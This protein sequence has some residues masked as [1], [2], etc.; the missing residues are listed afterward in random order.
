MNIIKITS[1]DMPLYAE[2]EELYKNSFPVFEQRTAEQQIRAFLSPLYNLDIYEENGILIGFISYWDFTSYIYIEHFA[3]HN[4]HR[5]K[6]YG[7]RLLN[8]FVEKNHKM[9]ILEI[10]PIIDDISSA[11]LRFYQKCNF[12]ENPYNHVHPPYREG[13]EGHNLRVLTTE[14]SISEGEYR[15]FNSDLK[16]VVMV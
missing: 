13:Y 3:I 2:F 4:I 11:R 8:M 7:N 16:D 1:R 14:R 15:R 6:G 12:Y 9:V 5:G 10:D